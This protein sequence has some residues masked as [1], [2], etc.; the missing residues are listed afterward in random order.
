MSLDSRAG[1]TAPQSSPVMID[2]KTCFYPLGSFDYGLEKGADGKLKA[3]AVLGEPFKRE[4]EIVDDPTLG[5]DA[6]F[7]LV[8]AIVLSD[9]EGVCDGNGEVVYD[10]QQCER[11]FE[12]ASTLHDI[13]R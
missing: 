10:H 7:T 2:P 3:T 8:D 5:P 4:F 12:L 6:G 11:L 13:R 1:R 9:G